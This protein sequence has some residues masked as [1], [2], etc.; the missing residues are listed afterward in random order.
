MGA[1]ASFTQAVERQTVRMKSLKDSADQS[2][3]TYSN[4]DLLPKFFFQNDEQA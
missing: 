4:W 3:T 1:F 2:T